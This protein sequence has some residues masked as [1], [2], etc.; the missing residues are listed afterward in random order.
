[1][2]AANDI[3]FV[4]YKRTPFGA[5]QGSLSSHTATDLAT[6]SA[7]GA[8]DVLKTKISA[9]NIDATFMGQ[10]VPSSKDGIYVARHVGLRLGVP[11]SSPALIVNRL[12]GSG[13]EAIVQGAQYLR[14]EE[15]NCVLVGGT[16][17]MTQVPYVLR[18]A[19]GGYRMGHSEIEDQLTASLTDMHVNMPMAITAENLAEQFRFS[20]QEVDEYA[21]L[22]QTRASKATAERF[23]KDEIHGITLKSKKGEVLLDRDEHIRPDSSL[24]SLSKLKP[25]FKKEGVVTAGN[26]SGVVDGAASLILTTRSFA[27]ERGLQVLGVLKS[28]AA[29]GCDPKIMGIGPVPATQLLLQK[30]S[31]LSDVPKKPSKAS[32]FDRVEINEAFSPQYL[33]VEKSLGLNREKTNILGGAIAIGH[34]LAASGARLVGTLL[35]DL[36]RRGGGWGLASACI[37]GGQGMSVAILVE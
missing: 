24:E 17:S 9:E 1:M 36:R 8:L 26:A 25:V 27:K 34:P 18:G 33:A 28:W 37:G 30:I 2:T 32:D 35:C 10:V 15:K 14:Q 20:R 13:F 12:C 21:L 22:S 31:K 7:Q 19:R 4:S 6:H 16:E 5:F 23:L 29:V 11:L 3:V